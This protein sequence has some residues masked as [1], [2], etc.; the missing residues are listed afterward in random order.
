[1]TNSYKY[2]NE[3]VDDNALPT[4]NLVVFLDLKKAF[5]NVNHE[6]LLGKLSAY[7]IQG[8]AQR[9][10]KSDR[11]QSCQV[12]GKFSDNRKITCG[13]P[14][15]SILGP[16]LF[17]IY[18]NDLTNCLERTTPWL[19]ADDS[20]KTAVGKTIEE[21]EMGLNNDLRNVGNWLAAS[22]LSLNISSKN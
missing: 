3:P 6:I 5:H 16:L 14:E 20:N 4:D 22:K 17:L 7:G 11:V 10:L 13:I 18:I 19:F 8:H 9:M 2:V 12:K 1:M 15:G 21:T